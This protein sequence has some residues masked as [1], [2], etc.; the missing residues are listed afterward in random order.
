[1]TRV[2]SLRRAKDVPEHGRVLL[3]GRGHHGVGSRRADGSVA[4]IKVRLTA[5]ASA[6]RGRERSCSPRTAGSRATPGPPR[7]RWVACSS[8][9]CCRRTTR[10]STSRCRRSVQA[11]IINDL[12]ERYPMIVV[13]QTVDKLKDAGFHW[14]TRSGVTVS[15]AD[16]LVPPEKPEILERLRG[17]GRRDREAVPAWCSEQA[18]AQRALWSR[19]GRKRPKRSVRP[20]RRTTP[21]TTRSRRS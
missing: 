10:S 8:T 18:G 19:S 5:A 6:A 17:A 20:A 11:T 21:T 7:P 9:S 1:M 16:V 3:A 14:A 12:A 13:A 15:M 4:Q 2:S